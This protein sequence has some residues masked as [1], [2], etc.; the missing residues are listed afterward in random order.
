MNGFNE[1]NK[2]KNLK[3]YSKDGQQILEAVSIFKKLGYRVVDGHFNINSAKEN[4]GVCAWDDREITSGWLAD[5]DFEQVTL[6]DLM[7][8][9]SL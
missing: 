6:E 1:L 8:L 4:G 9:K 2:F 5:D 7:I 3:F